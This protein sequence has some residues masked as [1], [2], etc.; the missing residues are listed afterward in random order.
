MADKKITDLNLHLEPELSDSLPIVNNSET[1]KVSYGTLYYGIRRGIVSGSSQITIGDTTGFTEFSSS[2][3]AS[4]AL[5][6]N[7][8]DLSN[9]ALISG[10][11]EFIGDQ[12][13][14]GS[15]FISG[16]TELGGDILPATPQG[17]NLGSVGRPFRELFLQS[18]SISI[19]SDTIGGPSAVISNFEGNVDIRAAGFSISSGSMT[20][21]EI[22]EQ[23]QIR[24][25]NSY[26]NPTNRATFEIIGNDNGN[27]AVAVNPGSLIH[28]T[29]F[30][31]ITNRSVFDSY[32]GS[33]I[34]SQL[35]LRNAA[36]TAA[37]PTSTVDGIIGRVATSGYIED[38][39][40]G[41]EGATGPPASMNF[42]TPG[43][44]SGSRETMIRFYATADNELDP[45]GYSAVIKAEGMEVT[46]SVDI[47]GTLTASLQ[48]NYVWLGDSSNTSHA[49]SLDDLADAGSFVQKGI[50]SCYSTSSQD[51]IVPGVEQPI[52]FDSIWVSNGITVENGN[53]ITFANPGTYKLEVLSTLENSNNDQQDAHFWLKLNGTNFPHSATKITAQSRKNNGEHSHTLLAMS[54]IGIAQ[55]VNDYVQIYWTGTST[56]L[57]LPYE[58]GTSVYPATP[59]IILNVIRVG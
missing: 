50:V 19:E 31:G 35:I 33:G 2:L 6:T 52:N 53:Q 27:N 13:I 9:Y 37:N 48:D 8:Q 49:V 3:S 7:E 40:F 15:L 47:Q 14:S 30:D 58:A 32:G 38:I 5:G 11:N 56:D 23:G 4:I 39:G 44:R 59:S 18:G 1:K 29:G 34:F 20:P 24:I 21:F 26:I 54:I 17:A 45:N 57:S 42:Y 36:G 25:R 28:I 51:L 10:G 22:D 55:N 43:Y 12:T 16:T 46:G 41:V